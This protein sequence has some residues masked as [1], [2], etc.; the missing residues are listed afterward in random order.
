MNK[1]KIVKQAY[2][3]INLAY[4]IRGVKF[5]M[6]PKFIRQA[7][8]DIYQ[9]AIKDYQEAVQN[10]IGEGMYQEYLK[11]QKKRGGKK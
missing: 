10:E 3:T 6:L 7:S 1:N 8:V 4:E 2:K 11:D 9:G 5:E